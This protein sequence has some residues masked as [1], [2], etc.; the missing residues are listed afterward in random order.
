MK[1][2]VIEAGNIGSLLGALLTD[3]GQDV[4]LVELRQDIVDA[5]RAGGVRIDMTDGRSL[6]TPVKITGDAQTVGVVGLVLVAVKANATPTAASFAEARD[7]AS[8][9]RSTRSWWRWSSSRRRRTVS[10]GR[11][12]QNYKMSIGGEWARR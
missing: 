2:S 3:A 7:L 4:T 9:P 5:V 1:I 10:D 12:V 11:A 8:G 6:Q